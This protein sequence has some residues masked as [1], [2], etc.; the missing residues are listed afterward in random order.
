MQA[1]VAV[2]AP[3][4]PQHCVSGRPGKPRETWRRPT[5]PD[6]FVGIDPASA[7]ERACPLAVG[8]PVDGRT[9]LGSEGRPVQIAPANHST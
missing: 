4:H 2:A 3:G 9:V 7:K 8:E 5:R 1:L 6:G